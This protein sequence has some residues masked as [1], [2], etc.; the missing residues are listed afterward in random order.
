[1]LAMGTFTLPLPKEEP[2]GIFGA[3]PLNRL[4]AFPI[5]QATESKH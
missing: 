1:M 2:V 3:G 4:D 5:V